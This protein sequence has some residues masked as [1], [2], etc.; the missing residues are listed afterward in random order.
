MRLTRPRAALLDWDNTL[1]DSFPA[2]HGAINATLAAMGHQQW[3]FEQTCAHIARSMRDFFPTKFGDRWEEARDVFYTSYAKRDL[4]SIQPMAGAAELLDALADAGIYLAVVSNKGGDILRE[5]VGHLGWEG[6]F[7]RVVGANDAA[8]DKPAPEVIDL[9]LEG[10]GIAPGQDVWFVG[11]NA[12][13][14]DCAE[15]A[16]C[17]ALVIRGRLVTGNEAA[18]GRAAR[19]FENCAALANLVREI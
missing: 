6:Y 8:A 10:S 13:D 4:D 9:A 19:Q 7:A 12:I 2:I 16:G 5:E 15:S 1:V 3:T 18:L 11:D 17:M 14:I